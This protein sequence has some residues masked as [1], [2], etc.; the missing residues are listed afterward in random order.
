[1]AHFAE[2]DEKGIVLRVL[3]VPDERADYGAQFLSDD[4]GLG[5]DGSRPAIQGV[6]AGALQG[7]VCSGMKSLV[8]FCCLSPSRHGGV[9]HR[10]NGIPRLHIPTVR[11]GFGMK[12][13]WPGSKRPSN[14]RRQATRW[15]R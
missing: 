4:L 9:I 11:T 8:L 15:T 6:I 7:R 10:G 13:A 3:V 2:I 14:L 1:M 12:P 5:V